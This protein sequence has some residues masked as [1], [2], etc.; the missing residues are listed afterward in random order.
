[1]R[2]EAYVL[3]EVSLYDYLYQSV[4]TQLACGALHQ[5][6]SLRRRPNCAGNTTLESQP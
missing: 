2:K 5:G 6:D 4:L 1:M 3:K